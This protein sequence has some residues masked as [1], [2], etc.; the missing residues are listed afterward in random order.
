M[1][2]Y[3]NYLLIIFISINSIFSL[4][5]NEYESNN[6]Q[7]AIQN[8]LSIIDLDD[9]NVNIEES[10]CQKVIDTLIY[11][12]KEI[13]IYTDI[14]K[15]P[16]NKDYYGSVDI[17]E[18]L[19]NIDIHDI[20][21]YD[22]FRSIKRILAKLKDFHVRFVASK[23][24]QN[25]ICI[26]NLIMC[27]PISLIIKGNSSE[28][29]E[30]YIQKNE[31]CLKY[32]DNETID[33]I[34]ENLDNPLETINGTNAFD[35]IQNFGTQFVNMKGQHG[36]FSFFLENIPYFEITR[37]PFTKKETSNIEFI[38]CDGQNIT[39]DYHILNLKEKLQTSK[40]FND[41]YNKEI[42]EQK[43]INDYAE[44]NSLFNTYKNFI[45]LKNNNNKNEEEKIVWKYSTK[46]PKGFQCLIDDK[47]QVNVFKQETFQLL[48]DL[49]DIVDKCCEEFHKNTYPIIGIESKNQGG[50]AVASLVVRQLIQVKILSRIHE[51]IKYSDY[52]KNNINNLGIELYDIETCEKIKELK[53]IIDDY[54]NGIKHHRSQLTQRIN[55]EFIKR[56]KEKR[57]KY[58][59]YNH[60]KKPTEIL[61]F[62]DFYSFSTTSFFFKGFQET[63]GAIIVGYKGNPKNNKNLD[64]SLSASGTFISLFDTDLHKNL[65]ENEFKINT[66]TFRESYNYSYQASNPTPREY[67]VNPVDERVNIY[68][69]YDDSLYETFIQE[70]K[71]IFKKY[72]EEQ[73]CNPDNL[74]LTYEPDDKKCYTFKN[75]P[76]AHGGYECDKETKK[77]SNKCK[78]YYCDIG[79]YFDNYQNKCIKDVCTEGNDDG[80]NNSILI[81]K[82]F[83]GIII[84]FIILFG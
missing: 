22:F 24:I 2:S 17:I 65:T 82:S 29:A 34:N 57:Q 16:P 32:Y 41:F 44:K 18:E 40:E 53:E 45:E 6:Y 4:L 69:K 81:N 64:S 78:P 26:E 15:F 72:N 63:G 10:K 27:L 80:E 77:W 23:C 21:Y 1:K 46:N 31:D 33:L 30:V 75:I 68:Q 35:F 3:C 43:K 52:L 60:I 84:T 62:T 20:K 54:G 9:F 25:G 48:D 47:N 70:A 73:K 37:F 39:L 14:A 51:S 59:K 50:N 79:Y 19:N 7:N 42:I 8:N 67:L 28:N 13:Y 76:H 55:S 66:F 58:Y 56:L 5:E 83:L 12:M 38:F 61:I 71:K 49:E 11:L 36:T 74:L